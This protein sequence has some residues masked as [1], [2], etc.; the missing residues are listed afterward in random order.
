MQQT[1]ASANA[2]HQWLI[3][4]TW[5]IWTVSPPTVSVGGLALVLTALTVP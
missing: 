4:V 5:L 1:F 2:D 3:E